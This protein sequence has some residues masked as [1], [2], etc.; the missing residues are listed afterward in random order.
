MKKLLKSISILSVLLLA[1]PAFAQVMTANNGLYV[2]GA[3]EVRQGANLGEDTYI[4]GTD[5]ENNVWSYGVVNAADI[6]FT[7]NGSGQFLFNN[8]P[9]NFRS[10]D[11]EITG[12]QNLAT[13]N[14]IGTGLFTDTSDLF[15]GTNLTNQASAPVGSVLTMMSIGHPAHSSGTGA[16]L[17]EWQTLPITGCIDGLQMVGSV[18]HIGGLLTSANATINGDQQ[19]WGFNMVNLK[20]S[21]YSA[22]KLYIHSLPGLLGTP[23]DLAIV[24]DAN[25]ILYTGAKLSVGDGSNSGIFFDKPTGNTYLATNAS[26]LATQHDGQ[27]LVSRGNSGI[28]FPGVSSTYGAPRLQYENVPKYHSSDTVTITVGVGAGLGGSITKLWGTPESGEVVV[29]TGTGSTGASYATLFTI[30]PGT[31]FPNTHYHYIIDPSSTT[32]MDLNVLQKPGNLTVNNTISVAT[33]SRGKNQLPNAGTDY[34][35]IYQLVQE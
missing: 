13:S 7:G 19:T 9:A 30:T 25:T 12:V 8:G 24:G 16:G 10:Q 32:T 28:S 21:E 23:G 18:C 20:D 33:I 31:A 22:N 2:T 26:N 11:T 4:Q 17:A 15:L 35:F 6:A 29:H 27:V 1:T 14:G 5:P 3:S 34:S